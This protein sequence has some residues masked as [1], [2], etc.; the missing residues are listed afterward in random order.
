VVNIIGYRVCIGVLNGSHHGKWHYLL[1]ALVFDLF[2]TSGINC[3]D[4]NH[5]AFRASVQRKRGRDLDVCAVLYVEMLVSLKISDGDWLNRPASDVW[6]ALGLAS[7]INC[8]LPG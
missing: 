1:V 2:V 3:A 7:L 8:R 4:V 5:A 6:E